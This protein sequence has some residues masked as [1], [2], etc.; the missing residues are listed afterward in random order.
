MAFTLFKNPE[1]GAKDESQY[2]A[3]LKAGEYKLFFDRLVD[4]YPT[5]QFNSEV[6]FAGRA[7]AKN[8]TAGM[9]FLDKW[10]M[11]KHPLTRSIEAELLLQAS[12]G[13]E[14]WPR[15]IAK[16]PGADIV[17][18]EQIA[19][20]AIKLIS[21]KDP[22]VSGLAEFAISVRVGIENSESLRVFPSANN[23]PAW[24]NTW[25][26]ALGGDASLRFDYV[27]Q[28]ALLG[29]HRSDML[30]KKEADRILNATRSIV[31]I[32]VEKSQARDFSPLLNQMKAIEN[33][34]ND[35]KDEN[36]L[37]IKREKYID[38]RKASR[39]IVLLNPDF[40]F[41]KIVFAMHHAFHDLGNI[42]NGAKFYVIKP[43]GDIYIKNGFT[44]QSSLTPLLGKKLGP[45]HTRGFELHYD[46]DKIVF[47][48][49]PQPH[50]YQDTLKESDQGFDDKI[51]GMSE[52]NHIY[53]VDLNG[54]VRQIT[55]EK[56]NTDIEPTYLP[57]GDIVF[58]SD[59]SNFGSQC[60]G[61]YYQD[62]KIT[63]Q[64][65]MSPDGTNIRPLTHNKD[66][67]RY[68]HVLDNGQLIYTR[69]EYQERHLW[70]THNLWTSKPDG[71]M[72]DGLFKQHI[73]SISPQA[74][75][76]ARQIS[77]SDKL[78]AIACGHHE[79]EQGAVVIIDPRVGL[80]DVGGMKYVTPGISKRE[81][82]LGKADAVPEGGIKDNGGLYQQPFA[83]SE[84]SFLVAY[85]YNFPRHISHGYNFGL[86]YIDVFG[87]KELIHRDPVLSV[88]YPTPLKKRKLPPVI[89]DSP[90]IDQGSGKLYVTDVYED[91]PE[92]QK[93]TIKYIRINH[94]TEW[95]TI[96][97]SDKT[98]DFNHLH[99]VPSGSWSRTLGMSTWN[100]VRVIG[101]VPVEDDGSAYFE[102]PG[103]LPIYF[104]ALDENMVEVRRMRSFVSINSGETRGCTGCHET[105][106]QAPVALR[107]VP[108]ALQREASRPKPPQW[109]NTDIP[110][111]EKDIHPIFANNC[112]SCHGPERPAAGL[113]FS[114]RKIDGYYQ[115]YRTL[116][117][118]KAT[119]PTPVE[120]I[121][122]FEM[123]QGKGHNVVADKAAL[124]KM[125]RNEY[126][127]QLITISNKFSDNSVTNVRQFGS[128]NSKLIQTLLS[129]SHKNKV[130][131]TQE[132]WESLVT[133]IDL[134][135]P[136]WGTFVDKDPVRNGGTPQRV[137]VKFPE[138]F[139]KN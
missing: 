137:K 17:T 48:F 63:N 104:Q 117:G 131:M 132:D 110:D 28:A 6:E 91:V 113:E 54:E 128:G 109:G 108:K 126:P 103:N 24:Y 71:S 139:A 118:L 80:N 93:G 88:W 138:P 51:H 94:T 81:G 47:S 106:D 23:R 86:Y 100:P 61:S 115:A 90:G 101:T 130:K 127:G 129:A 1:N 14:A 43:G 45:G 96:K 15:D 20:R 123:T 2:A 112:S 41:E 34:V 59:R 58:S 52:P 35:L 74:L 87:N 49:S 64:H 19:T 67:D 7:I 11:E 50:Y 21:D 18:T 83:L 8:A 99:Y 122:S 114:S 44:P 9:K 77:G 121:K 26:S 29:I 4:I 82:G 76:D 55:N 16:I 89:T 95:P 98:H 39:E 10:H 60:S 75:R 66:F 70:Q 53:E 62:K 120:D 5:G 69:W 57:N 3:M 111:Y 36:D 38:L 65:R 97:K 116:F 136:Y 133:W 37:F 25:E 135:A 84:R 85:S 78:V 72:S 46:A 30:L 27:R 33:M 22:F 125:E 31:P 13:P 56:Y 105:R 12:R 68:N 92:I 107:Y 73:N 40:D 119:E 32:I 102:V 134:N 42:T 79:W 124:Q